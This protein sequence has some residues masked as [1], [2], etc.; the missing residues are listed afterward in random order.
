MRA[1]PVGEC[2]EVGASEGAGTLPSCADPGH[3]PT[4]NSR[5]CSTLSHCGQGGPTSVRITVWSELGF[6]LAGL[7]PRGSFEPLTVIEELEPVFGLVAD[8]QLGDPGGLYFTIPER[9][10][11]QIGFDPQHGVSR[12]MTLNEQARIIWAIALA[13]RRCGAQLA[14]LLDDSLTLCAEWGAASGASGCPCHRLASV[15]T[16]GGL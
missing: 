1:S 15:T 5:G 3:S 11:R 7:A 8:V 2:P 16:T 6:A 14:E 13:C 4:R 10:D 12:E 9:T